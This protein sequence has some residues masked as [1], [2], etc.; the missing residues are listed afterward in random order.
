MP[1]FLATYHSFILPIQFLLKRLC[2]L[3]GSSCPGLRQDVD[4]R[5]TPPFPK[6]TH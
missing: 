4:T 1:Q 5:E 3:S 2:Q 6:G